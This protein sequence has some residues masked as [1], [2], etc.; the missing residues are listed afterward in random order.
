MNFISSIYLWL[1]PLI[2]VPLLIYLFNKNK[3]RNLE[4][5]SLFFLNKIKNESIKKIN[6]INIILLI[7]RTLIILFFILMMSRPTYNSL[8]QNNKNAEALVILAIDNSVSM[9]NSLDGKIK[10]VIKNTIEPFKE[11]S[12]IKLI[13]LGKNETVYN[14]KKENLNLGSMKI[15][16]TFRNINSKSINK[17]IEENTQSLNTFLFIISDGQEHLDISK[18]NMPEEKNLYV[19]YLYTN[20]KTNNL[21]VANVKTDKKILLPSDRF[22]IF[23]TLQNNGKN[24]IKNNFVN[25]IVND[26]KVGKKQISLAAKKSTVIEFETSIPNYGQHLCKIELSE[27]Q[28]RDDNNYYFTLNI[29]NTIDIDII[30]NKENIYLDNIL[31][32]F[33][34]SSDIIKTQYHTSNNYINKKIDANILFILGLDNITKELSDKIYGHKYSDNFKVIIIPDISDLNF[35]KIEYFIENT[36]LTESSRMVYQ[37]DTY[38]EMKA[39][40]IKDSFIYELYKDYPSRN[41]KIF[42]YIASKS[43]Q[44]TVIRLENN[45]ALWNRFIPKNKNIEFNISAISFNLNSSNWIL[46]G[47]II[48]FMQYLII[49]EDLIDYHEIDNPISEIKLN[50]N[51]KLTSPK[52]NSINISNTNTKSFFNEL[53][54]YKKVSNGKESHIAVN[55]GKEELI[56]K[57]LSYNELKDLSDNDINIFKTAKD[58][59]N[60]INNRVIGNELWR[61]FLYLMLAL[62]FLEMFIVNI[63]IKND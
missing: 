33:N 49:N 9:S 13:T 19:T 63:Y 21:S 45:N 38:L 60:Y 58:A 15:K 18:I 7:I 46:K 51:S 2:S 50:T 3:I 16:T 24:D 61:I 32:S 28:I 17:I 48:P 10:D 43:N 5:S 39:E 6:I 44:N 41:I 25:L 57:H 31:N 29:Q 42:N 30:S 53:G 56:S 59:S 55:L 14:G 8:Y 12:K 52:E 34:L 11:S 20:D 54:F 23:V 35:N 62:I 36:S 37:D 26:I 1:L 4:F 27:D 22:K 40:Y 47:S